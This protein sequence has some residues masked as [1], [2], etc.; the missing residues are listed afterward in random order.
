MSK[1]Y[2][3]RRANGDWFAFDVGGRL[4]VPLFQG[5][6]AAVLSRLRNSEMLLFKPVELD[7]QLLKEMFPV[8]DASQIDFCVI[9]DPSRSL[10]KGIVIE[11][12][13]VAE[14]VTRSF[15]AGIVP[16]IEAVPL[17][18]STSLPKPAMT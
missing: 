5:R 11:H 7:P 18:V 2:A 16:N 10:K 4:R 6:E 9:R 1:T 12:A 8:G 14:Q 13:K 3:M 15:A 17:A